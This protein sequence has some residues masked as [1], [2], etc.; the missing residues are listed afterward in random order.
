[1]NYTLGHLLLTVVLYILLPRIIRVGTPP[2]C[3]TR[4]G[5]QW[6]NK[7]ETEPDYDVTVSDF[8]VH[9]GLA[10]LFGAFG[11]LAC[12]IKRRVGDFVT[13]GT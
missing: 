6:G 4:N 11:G 10:V 9:A 5:V 3:C 2:I 12:A 7:T 1:M 13:S 8:S